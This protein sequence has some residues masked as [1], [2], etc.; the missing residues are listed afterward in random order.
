MIAQI[1]NAVLRSGIVESDEYDDVIQ[2]PQIGP[3]RE[4]HRH[5]DGYVTFSSKSDDDLYPRVA[6][7]AGEL[8]TIFPQFV[9]RFCKDSYVSINAGYRLAETTKRGAP[10]KQ[11]GRPKHSTDSLKYLCACYVD[12]DFYKAG[13]TF[14]TVF[15]R[16]I[17]L[18]DR[19][20]IP[21][22]SIIVRS[23][24]GMWLLW[25]LRH[26]TD[27]NKSQEAWQEKVIAYCAIN[28]ELTHRLLNLGA[29]S[30]ANDAARH[31]RLPG[32]FHT[33]G[34]RYVTWWPQRDQFGNGYVYT[35]AELTDFCGIKKR[36]IPAR[37]FVVG[38]P[39]RE[40]NQ[41]K[42]AGWIALYTRR[43]KD[44]QTLIA[45]RGGGFD[46][47]C[48][49]HGA[50]LYAWLLRKNSCAQR[51]AATEVAALGRS[52]RPPMGAGAV[53]SA[54]KSG[55]KRGKG[56]I[57]K[58]RDQTISDW[59]TVTP[60]EAQY[61]GFPP[62]TRFGPPASGVLPERRQDGVADRRRAI[63]NIVELEGVTPPCRNMA[64][65][66]KA[67]NFDVNHV[68]VSGDYKVL[69]LKPLR[70]QQREAKQAAASQQAWLIPAA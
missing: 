50:M 41:S 9:E 47:G 25:L 29:D 54:V 27:P 69:G 67:Y 62:A 28:R 24:R 48:R 37:R 36:D 5:H 23:G 65:L 45:L 17:D 35:L 44:L 2:H 18:Q 53:R 19:G 39:K 46:T 11:Y 64:E 26:K 13:L 42:R 66:L 34:E 10:L 20:V 21:P 7:L 31:I 4:L 57:V 14:G 61:L 32:S 33:E 6:I 51:E 55:F 22:A 12:L 58:M 70:V 16:V 30:Q 8:E 68:T 3:I 59:L 15:G 49:S 43:L 40:K 1:D 38:N 60:S 56:E 63:Q 52:C